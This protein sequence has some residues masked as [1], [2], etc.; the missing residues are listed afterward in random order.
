M[1]ATPIAVSPTGG[2][3]DDGE[4]GDAGDDGGAGGLM[5]SSLPCGLPLGT[6]VEEAVE[7]FVGPQFAVPDE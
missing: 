1:A 6:G 7:V 5:E 2:R 3:E 4:V